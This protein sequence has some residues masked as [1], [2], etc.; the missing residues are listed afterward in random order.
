MALLN[1]NA[2]NVDPSQ[3]F[4]P[5]EPG[6]YTVQIVESETKPTKD[7]ASTGNA[8]LE[9]VLAVLDPQ[10]KNRQLYYRLNLKNNNPAAQEIAYKQLSAICHA[11]GVIQVEDSK[12]LHGLPFKVRVVVRKDDSGRYD[13]TNE[14]KAVKSVMD[15]G[16]AMAQPPIGFA[17]PAAPTMATAPQPAPAAMTAGPVGG[18]LPPWMQKK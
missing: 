14:V 8:Y 2:A 9:L 18:A 7:S 4:E 3:T 16:P 17:V 13:P 10:F 11:T 15:N 5:L 6:W 1:F 12:Q